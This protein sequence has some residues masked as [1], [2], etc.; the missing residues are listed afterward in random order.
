MGLTGVLLKMKKLFLTA[1]IACS[2]TMVAKSQTGGIMEYKPLT[3]YSNNSSSRIED[4]SASILDA[5]Y[6]DG[7]NNRPVKI[8][9]K[10]VV[11]KYGA[12]IV[13]CKRLTDDNWYSFSEPRQA[14]KLLRSSSLAD[15]FEF[16]VF[17]PIYQKT[18]YF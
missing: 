2:I 13:A 8:K 12:F 11:N 14:R 4:A 1:I 6:L 9:V 18:I 5:Y 10:A 3:P 15:Y 16:Q 7:V 17:L